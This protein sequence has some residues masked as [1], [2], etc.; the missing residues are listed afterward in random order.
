MTRTQ[1]GDAYKIGLRRTIAFLLSRGVP[2][3]AVADVAQ[4]AWMRGW[5]RL[6]QLRDDRMILP[7][8]CTIALNQYRQIARTRS[9]EE[10]WKPAHAD[11]LTTALNCAAIDIA[12]ILRCCEP[13][14]RQLLSAQ[15]SGATAEELAEQNGVS[16]SAMRVRMYRARKRARQTVPLRLLTAAA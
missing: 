11:L 15:L 9:L 7:W 6:Q 13:A 16:A 8:I 2:R 5:E 12:G 10:E 1:F 14:D 3:D 4:S